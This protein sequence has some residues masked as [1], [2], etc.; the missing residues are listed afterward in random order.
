MSKLTKQDR[1]KSPLQIRRQ[2]YFSQE[3]KRQKVREL[4]AK[5]ISIAQVAALYGVSRQTVYNWLYRYSEHHKQ[6]SRIVVEM[7]S[8]AR[9]TERLQERVKELERIVGQKQ[10]EIDYLSKL[11]EIS[12]EQLG[13]DLKKNYAIKHSSGSDSTPSDIAGL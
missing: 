11:I 12:S 8:E 6:Q 2:R 5:L 9:K 3:F 1:Q 4:D 7:E 13:V 10:I